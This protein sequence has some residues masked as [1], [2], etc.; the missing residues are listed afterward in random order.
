VHEEHA[1]S[2]PRLPSQLGRRLPRSPGPQR[3]RPPGPPPAVPEPTTRITD[4]GPNTFQR[5]PR[6]ADSP[7]GSVHFHA[8][9]VV[10]LAPCS[11][12]HAPGGSPTDGTR[13]GCARLRPCRRLDV[14]RAPLPSGGKGFT[15]WCGGRAGRGDGRSERSA[16][17]LVAGLI[18]GNEAEARDRAHP[19][20][21]H[22]TFE[23]RAVVASS[24]NP[25]GVGRHRQNARVST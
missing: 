15:T 24:V 1:P 2:A 5:R 14:G 3:L 18:H 8:R 16:K 7:S 20:A 25:D 4:F 21:L 13:S 10:S 12:P 22:R 11:S 17:A 9:W 23:S 6:S 19:Q